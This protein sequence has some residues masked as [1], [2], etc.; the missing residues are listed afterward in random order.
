VVFEQILAPAK[1]NTATGNGAGAGAPG[2]EQVQGQIPGSNQVVLF[3]IRRQAYEGAASA[4][5]KMLQA[6]SLQYWATKAPQTGD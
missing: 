5:A 2:R 3:V 6:D 1:S 4:H